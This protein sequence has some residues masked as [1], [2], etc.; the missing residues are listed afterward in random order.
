MVIKQLYT[1]ATTSSLFG[2]GPHSD[3]SSYFSCN[4]NESSILSCSDYSISSCYYP[5]DAGVKCEGMNLI[6]LRSYKLIIKFLHISFVS[7][8]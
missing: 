7:S 3:H 1:G 5:Y 4:G 2:K 6:N 8:M